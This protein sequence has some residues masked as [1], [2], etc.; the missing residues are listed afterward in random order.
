MSTVLCSI[1]LDA[2]PVVVYVWEGEWHA[3]ESFT[4][5]FAHWDFDYFISNFLHALSKV[6][7]KMIHSPPITHP[8]VFVFIELPW[9]KRR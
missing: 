4:K 8:L 9:M 7:D 2:F 3:N 5:F 6:G 1:L